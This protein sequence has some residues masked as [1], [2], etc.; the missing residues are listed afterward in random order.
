[1]VKTLQESEAQLSELVERASRGEDVTITVNGEAKARLT[2][3]EKVLPQPRTFDPEAKK[4]WVD[5]LRAS[6]RA[7]STG[8]EGLSGQEILDEMR[9]ERL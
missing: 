2:K 9:E 8:K 3:V 7:A 1:M 5:E 4:K 6:A